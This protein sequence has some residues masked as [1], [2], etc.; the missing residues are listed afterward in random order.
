MAPATTNGTC[1]LSQ[2]QPRKLTKIEREIQS[3]GVAN[4][5]GRFPASDFVAY[6]APSADLIISCGCVP[7]DISA[8]KVLLLHDAET[9][10]TQLP[11]GRKN[12][13]ET[14][15]EAALRET[16]EETGIPFKPLP[17]KVPTRATPT[18]AMMPQVR[19]TANGYAEEVTREIVNVEP[20]AV[21]YHRCSSTLAFKMVFWYAAVGDST[22]NPEDG[23]RE[24]WEDQYSIEWVDAKDA[25]GRMSMPADGEVVEKVLQDARLSGYDI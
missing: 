5:N 22:A 19:K 2:P 4:A 15:H 10:I 14:T 9:G 6:C 21:G 12:I 17:M 24:P 25:A 11:K 1:H 20:S 16:Y 3:R 13:G 18:E 7:L 8:R 23:T